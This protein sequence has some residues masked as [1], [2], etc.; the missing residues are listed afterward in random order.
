MDWLI[1]MCSMMEIME[2]YTHELEERLV[3]RKDP[4]DMALVADDVAL[5]L[6]HVSVKPSCSALATFTDSRT[7][8]MMMMCVD[9]AAAERQSDS[10]RL[11]KLVNDAAI[12]M[13]VLDEV[14]I[15]Q[16]TGKNAS[17]IVAVHP[18]LSATFETPVQQLLAIA[19]QAVAQVRR[20]SVTNRLVFK[21][22]QRKRS[23]GA[24]SPGCTFFL[25]K[26]TFF[27]C[28]PQNTGRQRRFTVKIKQIKRSDMVTFLFFVHT[29][30]EAKQYAGPD[31]ADLPARSFDLA[32]PGVAPSLF[33]K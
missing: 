20:K 11:V 8:V 31:R 5:N 23:K 28:R 13:S 18:N 17:V 21:Q 15:V 24:R 33:I 2:D 14:I 25:K 9:S 32:R 19:R 27:S 26:L 3:D 30:T 1:D 29:I 7:A 10:S 4:G 16:D 22:W 6:E 12:A